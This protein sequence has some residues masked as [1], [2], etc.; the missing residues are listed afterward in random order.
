MKIG[1]KHCKIAIGWGKAGGRLRRRQFRGL[2]TEMQKRECDGRQQLRNRNTPRADD[3]DGW[4]SFKSMA[5]SARD[6]WQRRKAKRTAWN[7]LLHRQATALSEGLL[8]GLSVLAG[9][10]TGIKRGRHTRTIRKSRGRGG[11]QGRAGVGEACA[12]NL[13][14][15]RGAVPSRDDSPRTVRCGLPAG[16][17]RQGTIT[18]AGTRCRIT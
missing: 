5:G 12:T 13:R 4:G 8:S 9:K 6:L 10:L 11:S 14:V 7:C 16:G 15:H 17:S 18:A 1:I 2:Y 3:C